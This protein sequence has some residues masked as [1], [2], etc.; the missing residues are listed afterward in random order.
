MDQG[1][2]I[3]IPSFDAS[4]MSPELTST[5]KRCLTFKTR[6]LTPK[7]VKI[8]S[9]KSKVYY[10]K[11]KSMNLT[12]A[13][14][15]SKLIIKTVLNMIKPI[16][17]PVVYNFIKCQLINNNFVSKY[18]RRWS[19][20]DKNFCLQLY[21]S[22]PKAYNTLR[23]LLNLPCKSTLVKM[24]S[25]IQLEPGFSPVIFSCFELV[26]KNLKLHDKICIVSFDEMTLKPGLV[27]DKK[28]DRLVGYEN[29]GSSLESSSNL[30]TH[31]LVF[32]VRGLCKRWKQAVGFFF[33]SHT[34]PAPILKALLTELLEKL[35]QCGMRPV[36]VVC[37]QGANNLQL[38]S[39]ELC[40]TIEKPFFNVCDN[41][42]FTFF[43]VPHLLKCL[44][45]NFKNYPVKFELDKIASWTHIEKLFEIDSKLKHRSC[46]KLTKKHIE[47]DGL[48]KMSVKLAAQIFSKRV[49]STLC[50]LN[51]C[52]CLPYS[53]TFTADF[54]SSINDLFDS[55]NSRV[56]VHPTVSLLS[57]VTKS[58]SHLQT[59][60]KSLDLIKS[61]EF[62]TEGKKR[63][64]PFPCLKGW[65]ITLSACMLLVPKLLDTVP[66]ILMS[67]FNQDALENFFSVVR[68]K[69]GNNDHPTA[70]DF[71]HR[72]R[73]LIAQNIISTSGM[74]NCKPDYDAVLIPTQVLTSHVI[75]LCDTD[76]N[77]SVTSTDELNATNITSDSLE[78]NTA[79]YVAGF[80][81]KRTSQQFQCATCTMN[82]IVDKTSPE[83][84]RQRGETFLINCREFENV[85][86]GL[87]IP[88][89]NLAMTICVMGEKFDSLFSELSHKQNVKNKIVSSLMHIKH[90]WL[91]CS[92]HASE[93][94]TFIVNYYVQ[95]M[96]YYNAKFLSRSLGNQRKASKKLAKLN[97]QTTV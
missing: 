91:S 78:M 74:T 1:T 93:A 5:P 73:I 8:K 55:L 48:S 19:V 3:D 63:Q 45:N 60:S 26:A 77:E 37:D 51:A 2:E 69:G 9:L 62:V 95:T 10:L 25:G 92:L 71:Q 29:Y 43:D 47:V 44:R 58:S 52:G 33:S 86:E 41:E 36:A 28:K 38:Y 50:L 80:V 16:V 13:P 17:K 94:W 56:L 35:I 53:A 11:R 84:T 30:A 24:I 64:I 27:Y 75:D 65:Q 70:S 61:I 32:M 67:R 23:D 31:A 76:E 49:S 87:I 97:S 82:L 34:T 15:N 20:T 21:L 57:A 18:G 22:S 59:W 96:I 46:P 12:K 72:A 89:K 68:R 6:N 39:K 83:Q 79:T 54:C 81:A 90:D 88:T 85:K 40:V 7:T 4:T 14:K 66:L 42:I